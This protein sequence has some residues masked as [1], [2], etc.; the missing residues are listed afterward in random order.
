MQSPHEMQM[1]NQ[2]V[3][4]L[5]LSTIWNLLEKFSSMLYTNPWNIVSSFP[6][7]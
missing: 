2:Y 6:M 5:V 4:V 1:A 7:K 3:Q